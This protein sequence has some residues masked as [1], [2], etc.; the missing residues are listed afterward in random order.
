[1]PTKPTLKEL[2]AEAQRL[3]I[4]TESAGCSMHELFRQAGEQDDPFGYLAIYAPTGESTE[5]AEPTATTEDKP[6]VGEVGIAM[7]CDTREFIKG[8]DA[9]ASTIQ[10]AGVAILAP[11]VELIEIDVPFSDM[12][13]DGCYIS[14]HLD[15]R[16]TRRQGDTI[17]RIQ[18][19]LD[20][21]GARLANNRRVVT[22]ADA[23]RWLL[24]EIGREAIPAGPAETAVSPEVPLNSDQSP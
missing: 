21:A 10:S 20:A 19:G 15:V 24:E 13:L 8:M 11:V 9:A 5:Q 6:H 23:I 3:R 7:R 1:M 12:Q 18:L 4:T 14:C 17:R 2:R 22:Q 16:L